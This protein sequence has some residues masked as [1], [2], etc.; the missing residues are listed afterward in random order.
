MKTALAGICCL[1][2]C[3]GCTPE[4]K[5]IPPDIFSIDTMKVLVWEMTLAGEY[6]AHQKDEDTTIKSLNTTYFNE[7]LSVHHIDKKSF[8]KSFNFYQTHPFLNKKLLDSVSSYAG[9]Q[10]TLLYKKKE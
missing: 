9:R 10:R 5:K 6:A 4:D 2:L 7:V 1:M 8:T 3:F